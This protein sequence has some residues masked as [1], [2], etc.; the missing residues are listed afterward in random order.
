MSDDAQMLEPSVSSPHWR[1]AVGWLPD[2]G[3]WRPW[4][5]PPERADRAH[6]E[7]LLFPARM[8]AGVR[9]E[10][11]TDA[12]RLTLPVLFDEC[13]SSWPLDVTVDGELHARVAV[14][15]GQQ[16]LEIDLPAGEHDVVVWL[17]Q[18]GR[19][20]V[21][22]LGVYGAQVL[23]PLAP[24]LRWTAYGSSITQCTAAAGP[25]E[26]WPAI[27][28]QRLGWDLTCLGFGGQC[29]LDPIAEHA[30][31][32]TPAEVISLCL[33]I[34]IHGGATFS[35]RTFAPQVSGFVERVRG[36]HPQARLVVMTPIGSPPRE[37][38]PSAGGL[39]LVQMREAIGEVVGALNEHGAQIVLVD[40]L[41]IISVTEADRFEDKLHPGPDGYRLMGERLTATLGGLV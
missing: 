34:N 2:G 39:S 40:G 26:T 33:G 20:A 27:V 41:D 19:S 17:P 15:L 3:W 23:R 36:A 7:P 4:R 28:S 14:A 9:A 18:M 5:L 29:H 25:S 6:A 21:G 22:G 10:L 13:E 12:A 38:T 1:G 30:I 31:A 35:D 24:R 32:Q 37:T 8:A 11:R 16:V